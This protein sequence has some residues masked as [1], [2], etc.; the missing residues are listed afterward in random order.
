MAPA[1]QR[2]T[3]LRLSSA[4]EAA[5]NEK[6]GIKL[7]WSKVTGAEGYRIYRGNSGGEETTLKTVTSTVTAYTDKTVVS[8]NGKSYTYTVQPY[9]G[10]WDGSSEGVSTVRLTGVTLKKAAK[11]GSGIKLTWTRNSKAKGYEIYRKMN[12]GK[13]TKVKTITKNSTLSCVDKAVKH[14]KTYSYKVCA[15]KDTSTSQLS[16]T[17]TVKR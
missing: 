9:S 5:A 14:G 1:N 17:K 13:W 15:Y 7:T 16:N 8:A 6:N 3:I 4:G 2:K 10:Q 12:G 11:A